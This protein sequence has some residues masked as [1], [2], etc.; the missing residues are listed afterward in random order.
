MRCVFYLICFLSFS[1][2]L[3]AQD[4]ESAILRALQLRHP[5]AD[6]L[7]ETY[8]KNL[9]TANNPRQI[10]E[11]YIAWLLEEGRW[12]E[13]GTWAKSSKK[14]MTFEHQDLAMA[15]ADLSN[16]NTDKAFKAITA[17]KQNYAK[18]RWLSL[19]NLGIEISLMMNWDNAYYLTKRQDIISSNKPWAPYWLMQLD[20]KLLVENQTIDQYRSPKF[21]DQPFDEPWI[22]NLFLQAP[23]K[24]NPLPRRLRQQHS[25][26]E[27]DAWDICLRTE[28]Q[29]EVLLERLKKSYTQS[30]NDTDKWYFGISLVQFVLQEYPRWELSKI[31]TLWLEIQQLKPE[32]ISDDEVQ[33]MR[34]TDTKISAL[35]IEWQANDKAF[36]LWKSLY[37]SDLKKVPVRQRLAMAL[38]AIRFEDAEFLR[39]AF[40]QWEISK[41]PG[42]L[43]LRW[44][45]WLLSL[46]FRDSLPQWILDH[47]I[48]L[49]PSM[50]WI[51]L[52]RATMW[53]E[54]A[55]DP[56]L[57]QIT[58]DS[59]YYFL[60][61]AA[62]PEEGSSFAMSS[63][64]WRRL[65]TEGEVIDF[66]ILWQQSAQA[67]FKGLSLRHPNNDWQ[68]FIK[69]PNAYLFPIKDSQ[70]LGFGYTADIFSL[71]QVWPWDVIKSWEQSQEWDF[72]S[73]ARRLTWLAKHANRFSLS[74][75]LWQKEIQAR[76]KNALLDIS[77]IQFYLNSALE[78]ELWQQFDISAKRKAYHLA[79]LAKRWEDLRYL[80]EDQIWKNAEEPFKT[81][82]SYWHAM[83]WKELGI[84]RL[85]VKEFRHVAE[86]A[87]NQPMWASTARYNAAEILY[88]H[89]FFEE[90]ITLYQQVIDTEGKKT[91]QGK[92]AFDKLQQLKNNQ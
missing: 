73:V 67:I 79:R 28:G 4:N 41:T 66:P 33:Y 2:S 18:S 68:Q 61:V 57:L 63:W 11:P 64:F 49:Q 69:I 71:S 84:W 24:N 48:S 20:K 22:T 70:P 90:A 7:A 25:L 76:E 16:G 80:T 34:Q 27:Q 14:F 52:A 31:E 59:P 6:K 54:L 17:W 46:N 78:P 38:S 83:S 45:H 29:W 26:L 51:S 74:P 86:Y 10:M 87:K 43:E 40:E 5:Q 42:L 82:A 13:A 23:Q 89:E 1:L 19:A 75:K 88:Q 58:K 55:I 53:S 62:N 30:L 47:W 81:E 32:A 85:A 65:M 39:Q 36:P 15:M 21:E 35:L 91:V 37:K 56:D 9:K 8:L 44:Q 50:R 12:D 72:S 60:K 92:A 3:F 77:W